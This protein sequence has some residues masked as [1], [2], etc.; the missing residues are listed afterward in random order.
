MTV[1]RNGGR[2]AIYNMPFPHTEFAADLDEARLALRRYLSRTGKNE[3]WPFGTIWKV[4]E[5]GCLRAI[6]LVAF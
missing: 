2:W 6:A 4:R 1:E 3:E 5:P